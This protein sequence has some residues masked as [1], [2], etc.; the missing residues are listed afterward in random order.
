MPLDVTQA[1]RQI[2]DKSNPNP[3]QEEMFRAI[4]SQDCAVLLKAP[5]GSGKTEAVVVPCLA[6]N[7]SKDADEFRRRLFLILPA[8]S[9]VDDQVQ[10]LRE[11]IFPRASAL[12]D[13]PLALVVDT[14]AQSMRY[15][16]QN[17][18]P[19]PPQYRHL[20]D[21]D[22]I[23][24]TLDKFLYRFFGFGEKFKNYVFPF[25]IHYGARR[26]LFC[27]DEAHSYEDV[28]F[29]NFVDLVR[30]LAVDKGHDVV[31]MTATMP[32]DYEKELGFLTTLDFTNGANYQALHDFYRTMR[33][34]ESR[35]LIYNPCPT[36][37]LVN[38][39]IEKAKEHFAPSRRV[40]V[41]A[42]KV[43]DAVQV[44]D[45][46][47]QEFGDNV[48]LYHGRLPDQ[49]EGHPQLGRRE[50]YQ[51]LKELDEQENGQG[52]LLVTTSA[53]E[54]GC[55]LDAHTLITEICNPAQL[56]QRAGRC[57]RRGKI[58][59]AQVI[60]VGEKVKPF[61][62]EMD[63]EG[64]AE[65]HRALESMRGQPLDA[66]RI[67]ACIKK[68]VQFDY[69]VQMVFKMLYEY[70]YEANRLYARLHEKGLVITRSWQPS[71]T[72]CTGFDEYGNPQNAISANI[73]SCAAYEGKDL[74]SECQLFRRI[75]RGD[76]SHRFENRLVEEFSGCA[77]S[78]DL[79][80]Q[81]PNTMFDPQRGY[82]KL[83]NAFLAKS[84]RNAYKHWVVFHMDEERA[85]LIKKGH[86]K[87]SPKGVW[88]WY[89][90]R[91]P[92]VPE[93]EQEEEEDVD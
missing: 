28:A 42:E 18:K 74:I 68:R 56:L 30:T 25:R 79:M 63:D 71:V 31:V 61:L 37:Q 40:I 72:I 51:R 1:Y 22:V 8:R 48:L 83:P 58:A 44:Y 14:G 33:P 23:V 45:A 80:L 4:S 76:G 38:S 66:Q 64:E 9:L 73:E 5:T 6:A 10:R 82:E 93:E 85:K 88:F 41:T 43:E 11:K 27:F 34:H 75:Y 13:R 70:V 89:L 35:R 54:V 77:Y 3:M 78:V 36:N 62:R 49:V 65:Y 91:L 57:N 17:G 26:A 69:R 92:E 46:L 86:S 53:I 24:T 15:V 16:W 67:A 2:T 87:G 60:V 84:S 59:D 55:D 21:G 12:T 52:Y 20:Y 90:D 29:T 39:L 81:V 7:V 32:K 50:V 47:A 19:E